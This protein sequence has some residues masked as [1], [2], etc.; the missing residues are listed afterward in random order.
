MEDIK[1]RLGNYK[2][3]FFKNFQ[4]YLDTEIHFFGSIKRDDFFEKASDIDIIIVTDN[5]KSTLFKI[6]HYLNIDKNKIQKIFQQ[7]SV[8]DKGI[9]TGYKVKYENIE[10]DISFDLL[11]YEEKYRYEVM[12]N[13]NDINNLPTYMIIIL[14][15]L[16]ILYY[17]LHFITKSLYLYLKSFIFCCYFNKEFRYYKKEA[18]QTIMIDNF[19]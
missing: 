5:M 14:Y 3:N 12:K 15:I 17:K 11:I 7:Y 9:I 8:Y 10:T 18:T 19:N 16:K 2:Y 1:E 13:V 6:Q 4:D